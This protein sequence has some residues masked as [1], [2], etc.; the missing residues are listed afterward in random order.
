VTDERASLQ[1]VTGAAGAVLA[2]QPLCRSAELAERGRAVVF[3]LVHRGE[4]MRGF[5]LRIDGRVVAYLNR[6]VHRPVEMDWQPGEFLDALDQRW[7]VCSMHGAHYDAASG[8]CVAGPC[9]GGALTPVPVIERDGR[10]WWQ[11]SADLQP[12]P[13]GPR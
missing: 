12:P 4:P 1:R 10:V 2:P 7:I 13:D 8:R 6:C 3:D 5:A 11:P 9:A